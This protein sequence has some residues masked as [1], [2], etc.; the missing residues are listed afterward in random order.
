MTDKNSMLGWH[1][2]SVTA[3]DRSNMLGHRSCVFWFTG[4]PA[5]GKSTLANA[6]CKKL[7]DM[8][9]LSYVLDGDNVRHGLNR[10]L[11]FSPEERTENIRRIA[12][13]AGL[14]MDA[15]LIVMT[16]FIS[17]YRED[18]ERARKLIPEGDFIEVYVKCA[19]EE[20]ERRDPKGMY[21][22]ARKGQIQD[23]TGISAPYE[24]PA[25]PEIVLETDLLSLD[26]CVAR[27]IEYLRAKGYVAHFN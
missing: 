20:C 26:D 19:V 14:F 23:F 18:R 15:G 8:N 10:D 12:E 6:L 13:V 27:L 7:H 17:P 24:V 11:G 5:S 25:G 16:A 3:V 21:K 2:P 1:T 22:L 9:V 4:L